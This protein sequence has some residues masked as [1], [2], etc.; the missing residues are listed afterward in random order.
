MKD[1]VIEFNS[2]GYILKADEDALIARLNKLAPKSRLGHKTVW[3]YRFKDIEQMKKFINSELSSIKTREENKIK[4]KQEKKLLNT[5]Q[6][7]SVKA[8]DI[9]LSTWGY[10]QTNVDFYKIVQKLSPSK[11]KVQK[12]GFTSLESTSWCS[13][14]VVVDEDNLIGEEF[15]KMLTGDSIRINSFSSASKMENKNQKV[16]RSWGY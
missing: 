4:Q 2:L 8:G 14:D 15:I 1:L 10:E 5:K 6:K 9:L 7:E 11:V 16:Y 12:V 3:S 13:E